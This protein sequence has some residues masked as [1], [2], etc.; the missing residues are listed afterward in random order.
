MIFQNSFIFLGALFLFFLFILI[1]TILKWQ[2]LVDPDEDW[3]WSSG[4]RI[5]RLFGT[6]FLVKLNY[7]ISI[8]GIF[9]TL[10]LFILLLIA[11]INQ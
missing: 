9:G 2:F 7:T 4:A 11:Y 1:G 3:K 5:K 10:F 6:D 8:A